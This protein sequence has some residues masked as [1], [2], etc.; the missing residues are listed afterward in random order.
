MTKI[1]LICCV[2]VIL[3]ACRKELGNT[4]EVIPVKT[5]FQLN[6]TDNV[7]FTNDKGLLISGVFDYKY[8]LIKTN[9]N[10]EI[11]WA[12]NDFEWGNLY[13]GSGWGSSFYSLRFV[14]VIQRSN[15]N[16]IC[17][18]S[19]EEGGDVVSN[20]T[21]VIEL[22]QQGEQIRTVTFDKT[23]T[24]NALQTKDGGYL[25]FGLTLLKIDSNLNKLWEK[26]IYNNQYF[27]NEVTSIDDNNNIASTGSYNGD[28]VFLEK[29]DSNGNKFLNCLYMHNNEPL[30]EA[31]FDLVQLNDKGF[32]IIGRAPKIN[33]YNDL[34]FHIIR[35]NANGDTIW[36]RTFGSSKN[37]WLD[38]FVSNNQNEFVIQGSIGFPNENQASFLVRLNADGQI[39]DSISTEKFSMMLYSPLKYYIKVQSID[40][41]HVKF[42]TIEEDKLFI[43]V[44]N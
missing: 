15:G 5:T 18:G 34:D 21:I 41:A 32:L 12:K 28:Q 7:L 4:R 17:F 37:E 20:S 29:F 8:T 30:N 33:I 13:P 39:L 19:V 14:K 2:L 22:N 10:L 44:K 6:K 42:A 9:K 24:S 26:N 36:T 31:G 38:R 40:S 11:T 43:V 3:F 35:T 23:V 1:L 16:Y 25:L 27:Q